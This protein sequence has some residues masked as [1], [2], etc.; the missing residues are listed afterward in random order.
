MHCIPGELLL[1]KVAVAHMESADW[2]WLLE[3]AR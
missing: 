3:A 1:L 2:R